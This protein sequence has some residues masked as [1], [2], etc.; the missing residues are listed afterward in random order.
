MGSGQ[1]IIYKVASK[2]KSASLYLSWQVPKKQREKE[3]GEVTR[4]MRGRGRKR[5]GEMERKRGQERGGREERREEEERERER[6][7]IHP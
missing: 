2:N 1:Q 7:N 5:G 3:E 4:G 6:K